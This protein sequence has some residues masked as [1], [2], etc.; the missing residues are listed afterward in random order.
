LKRIAAPPPDTSGKLPRLKMSCK[1]I[2]RWKTA[3]LLNEND[4]QFQLQLK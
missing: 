1:M 3:E 4:F 2:A